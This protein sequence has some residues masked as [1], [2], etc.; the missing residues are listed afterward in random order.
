MELIVTRPAA[1]AVHAHGGRVYVWPK[2]RH[3]CGGGQT[4]EASFEPPTGREFQAV[5]NTAGIE[6]Y[7]PTHLGRFPDELHV[8]LQRHPRRIRAYWNGCVWVV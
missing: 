6:L 4:L 8:D 1:E 3:C 7:M 5:G 2:A